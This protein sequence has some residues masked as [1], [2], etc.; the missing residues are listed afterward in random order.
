MLRAIFF[1]FNGV[2]VDDEAIHFELLQRVLAEEDLTLGERE[3]YEDYVGFDDHGCFSEALVSAGR[4]V[5]ESLL[6]RLIARKASYYQDR[7]RSDGYTWPRES[8]HS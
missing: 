6:M 5:D 2:I 8:P 7:V 3:Y 4:D 1:D